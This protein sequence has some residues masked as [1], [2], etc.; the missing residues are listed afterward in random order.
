M[1]TDYSL[2]IQQVYAD[3][4]DTLLQNIAHHFKVSPEQTYSFQWYTK[5]LG[6]MGALNS[7]NI[8][9]IA[10][11]AKQADPMIELALQQ[12]MLDALYQD[13]R[14]LWAGAKAAFD[15]GDITQGLTDSLNQTLRNFSAQ[16]IEQTNLVNTVMLTQTDTAARRVLSTVRASQSTLTAASQTQLNLATGRVVTGTSTLQQSIRQALTR[17]ADDGITGFIDKAGH[18]WSAE[19]Y[20]AMDVQQTMHNVATETTF[21]RARSSDG[22]IYISINA[23]A[24]PGCAPWQGKVI[25]LNNESGT[26]LDLGD[27]RHKI[28]PVS[29]TTYGQPAGILGISCH[30]RASR[31]NPGLTSIRGENK[32]V[33]ELTDGYEVRKRRTDIEYQVKT[34]KRKAAVAKANGDMEGFEIQT[35]KSKAAQGRLRDYCEQTGLDYRKNRLQVYGYDRSA[36]QAARNVK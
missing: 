18:R 30:H 12:A 23:T 22:L 5:K 7:E 1:L 17:M 26:V 34:A 32:S 13:D 24:R 6:E 29:E 19:A 15:N 10:K 31:F 14:K 3:C 2:P 21:E 16:A 8:A 33:K 36:A 27:N 9:I 4:V 11:L 20:V 35:R 28:Y 25:S